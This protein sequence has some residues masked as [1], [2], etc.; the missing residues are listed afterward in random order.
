[1]SGCA[2]G[3][4]FGADG[5]ATGVGR[6]GVPAGEASAPGIA[7]LLQAGWAVAG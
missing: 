3:K 4:T 1:M 7:G 5:D 2:G 6:D